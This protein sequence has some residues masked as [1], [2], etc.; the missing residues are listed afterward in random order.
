MKYALILPTVKKGA[1][2]IFAFL[3]ILPD[4]K[5]PS[6]NISP[7]REAMP[8]AKNQPGKPINTPISAANLTSPIPNFPLVKKRIPKKI[9]KPVINSKNIISRGSL[10]LKIRNPNSSTIPGKT[11][12]LGIFFCLISIKE[13]VIDKSRNRVKNI[14]FSL[15]LFSRNS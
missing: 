3:F 4:N 7:K 11:I 10:K 12:Q 9:K 6:E 1:K 13:V 8:A 5:H 14:I 2:G 15:K